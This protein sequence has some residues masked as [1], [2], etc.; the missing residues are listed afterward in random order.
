MSTG[1]I[2]VLSNPL[3]SEHVL[4]G[5][6]TKT[7]I[8]RA[9]ELYTEGLL[10]PFKVVFAK[11]VINMES[12]LVSL[13]KLMGKFGERP[14]N[15]KDFFKIDPEV[16]TNLFDLIDGEKWTAPVE[17]GSW[18]GTYTA[19]MEKVGMIMKNENPKANEFQL[20]MLK[21]KVAAVLK[22]RYGESIEPTLELVREAMD[23][24]KREG[25]VTTVPV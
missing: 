18:I 15:D 19:L 13:H 3:Y 4:V 20:N 22:A 25:G 17:E 21:M 6:S 12:K 1:Y 23:A 5:T 2:Y 8:E 16:T 11:S 10:Y 9:A 7:P 14:N 24:A